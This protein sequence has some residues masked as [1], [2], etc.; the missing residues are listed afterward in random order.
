MI[1]TNNNN[2]QQRP[3]LQTRIDAITHPS[4]GTGNPYSQYIKPLVLFIRNT[5]NENYPFITNLILAI[6]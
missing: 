1:P 3:V 6:L 2:N 4:Y 5:L